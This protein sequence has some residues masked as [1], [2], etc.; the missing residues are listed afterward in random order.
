MREQLTS[1]HI[2]TIGKTQ[3]FE[4]LARS[5][6]VRVITGSSLGGSLLN[7]MVRN[8][9]SR[10]LNDG[11]SNLGYVRI[12]ILTLVF[13]HHGFVLTEFLSVDTDPP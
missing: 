3:T 4:R 9:L 2:C 1:P 5:F 13:D 6:S 10:K 8:P 11:R 7:G 12:V